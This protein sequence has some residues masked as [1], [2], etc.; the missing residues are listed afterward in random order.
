MKYLI[1]VILALAGC[2]TK[3]QLQA[4]R[5]PNLNTKGIQRI[6][7]MPFRSI[8]NY[9][10]AAKHATSVATS[11]IQ[12]INQFTLVSP[13]KIK[14]A[15]RKGE[16]LENYADALFI[17]QIINIEGKISNKQN[18]YKN[19]DGTIAMT[20]SYTR[21]VSVEFAY[22]LERVRDGLVI[23]PIIKK[24]GTNASANSP[25]ELPSVIEL[26]SKV[27][28]AQLSYLYRDLA[29]YTV[30]VQRTMEEDKNLKQPMEEALAH[31]KAGNY[32]AANKAYL[33]LWESRQSIAA[34]VNAAYLYEAMGETK[35]AA[36]LMQQV[37]AATRSPKANEVL[38]SLNKELLEQA[39]V[40]KFDG[41]RNR[42][43]TVASHA[44]SEV[45]K[46][47]FAEAKLWIHNSAVSDR[48]LVDG[49][50][51]NMTSAFVSNG[52]TVVERQVI[53]LI[54][55]ENN[56]QM[57]GSVNDDD[58]VR[59]GSLAGANTIVIIGTTGAGTTRR[60]Q[61]RVLDIETGT[62]IMQSGTDSKWNL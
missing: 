44:I 40:E 56:L 60:L 6:A 17:G 24:G 31:V 8:D 38:A 1:L 43:E 27:I 2:A 28:D 53:G 3:I 50:I 59:I 22:H 7:V 34:A 42:N 54:F 5:M 62:I 23:G 20:T 16:S 57:G 37:V 49:V 9:S 12:T 11:N 19:K 39:R 61:V 32:I 55:K 58:I 52:V 29:P 10:D 41:M 25:S 33:A 46:I 47:L 45:Q 51:D 21:E 4:Q 15:I 48:N 35:N 14:E 30:M 18:S 26:A 36:N 13:G